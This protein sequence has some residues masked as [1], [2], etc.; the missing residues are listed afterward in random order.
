[1]LHF[2]WQ[3]FHFDLSY[4]HLHEFSFNECALKQSLKLGVYKN[5]ALVINKTRK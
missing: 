3:H 2:V 4:F 5:A 1:M